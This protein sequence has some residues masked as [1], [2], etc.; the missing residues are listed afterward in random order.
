MSAICGQQRTEWVGTVEC[1]QPA[2]RC[3]G[4]A[5]HI[6][7]TTFEGEEVVI[8]WSDR[9]PNAVDITFPNRSKHV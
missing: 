9:F 8:G 5:D 4:G 6:A 1:G 7:R 2:E 3:H